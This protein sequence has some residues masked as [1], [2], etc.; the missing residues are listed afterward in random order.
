MLQNLYQYAFAFSTIQ[1]SFLI[2]TMSP[3]AAVPCSELVLGDGRFGHVFAIEEDE[4]GVDPA[5]L[6]IVATSESNDNIV[7]SNNA[8]CNIQTAE[9]NMTSMGSN[10]TEPVHPSCLGI[11]YVCIL[12]AHTVV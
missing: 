12:L 11:L 9:N 5:A 1:G 2:Y 8:E 4:N 6:F 10:D 3:R 7:E